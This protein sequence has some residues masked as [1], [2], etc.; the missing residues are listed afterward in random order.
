MKA[1]G[2]QLAR[3]VANLDNRL[4]EVEYEMLQKALAASDDKYYVSAF[5]IYF[6]LLWLNG[7]VG[8]GAGDVAGGADFGPTDKAPRLLDDL[9]KQLP[10]ATGHYH[11]LM[12]HDVPA[13]NRLLAA[14]GKEP[15]ITALGHEQEEEGADDEDDDFADAD[16][17]AA[18]DPA[19]AD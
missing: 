6:N 9:E 3:P 16:S 2:T 8:T 10:V 11:T 17:D 13:F 7:E 15:L 4:Q 1:D 5:K 12:D 18:D 19:E 14:K